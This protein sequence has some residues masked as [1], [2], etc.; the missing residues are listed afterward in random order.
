MDVTI[1]H[2]LFHIVSKED[3]TLNPVNL[4]EVQKRFSCITCV[5]P[6]LK[7]LLESKSI[8]SKKDDVLS[9]IAAFD[10]LKPVTI[11]AIIL[12]FNE[13]RGIKRCIENLS[14]CEFDEILVL[15][16]GSTDSTKQILSQLAPDIQNLTVIDV[17]WEDDFSKVRNL[18]I[19][20][21]QSEWVCFIDADE[22][23]KESNPYNIRE[24]ITFYHVFYHG[25]LCLCPNIIN[26]NQHELINNTRMFR[27][28]S[29]YRYYGQ[30]H[31]MLRLQEDSYD[32]LPYIGLDLK[33]DHTGYETEIYISKDKRNRNIR[34]LRK[35]I[36]T[37]PNHP[38]WRCYL[39][40]D[41]SR[42][43]PSQEL[44]YLCESACALSRG[45]D[46]ELYRYTYLWSKFLLMDH[47]LD[48]K[49]ASDAARV[50]EEIKESN[51]GWHE[52]DI[53]YREQLLNILQ[54]KN[55]MKSKLDE[56]KHYRM[57]HQ[58]TEGSALNSQGYHIDEIIMH[59]Y[60]LNHDLEQYR[61]YKDLLY[62]LHY[63]V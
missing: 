4:N 32:S 30:V 37:E 63:L 33:F 38:L 15:D 23:Y 14:T 53:Y 44:I 39:A 16:T 1:D 25:N 47:Y 48:K 49:Q 26:T 34:L 40:R 29:G 18:G 9:A 51:T 56:V 21:A 54:I 62:Q 22:Y 11:T 35:C 24:L 31:E 36:E 42:Q 10:N 8:D 7:K 43:L 46:G 59:L 17:V 13:E 27:K 45:K 20:E 12:C 2:S 57:E 61:K 19:D 3:K 28:G 50:L 5:S 55:L 41:G 60:E 58:N 6:D 52:S